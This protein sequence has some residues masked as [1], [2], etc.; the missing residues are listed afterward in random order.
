[1][2]LCPPD[3]LVALARDPAKLA[4]LGVAS[5]RFD[6]KAVETLVPGLEGVD[7]LVLISSSDFD[8]RVGQHANVIDAARTAGVGRIVYT[9]I[10]KADRSPLLIAQDHRDTEGLIARS[11]IPATILRNGWYTENWTAPLGGAIAAGALYGAAGDA[12]FTPAARQDYADA[13]A[14]VAASADHAGQV[15]ELAGDEGFTLA[16]LAAA[17]SRRIGRDLPYQD[18]P[19]SAYQALLEQIGL[20]AGFATLLVDVD[21]KAADGWLHDD[22]QTLSTLIGRPTTSLARMLDAAIP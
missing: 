9:S 2:T 17:V 13:L 6:Y 19:P 14:I 11:G 16:E 3:R 5:R 8:D 21:Q 22:T 7:T 12:R 1:M 4:D 10:L 20:P 15:Y 18:L